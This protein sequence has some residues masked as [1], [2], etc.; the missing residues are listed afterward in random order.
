MNNYQKSI[1]DNVVYL[2][3]ERIKNNYHII[4]SFEAVKF[5]EGIMSTFNEYVKIDNLDFNLSQEVKKNLTD[6]D[7]KE[8]VSKLNSLENLKSFIKDLDVICSKASFVKMILMNLYPEYIGN[9]L[10]FMEFAAILEP[11]KKEF[12]ADA[13]IREITNI[14]NIDMDEPVKLMISVNA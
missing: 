13:L 2:N 5:V 12:T 11:W 6:R 14:E 3:I 4:Y 7:I 1:L 9:V 8:A 10:D